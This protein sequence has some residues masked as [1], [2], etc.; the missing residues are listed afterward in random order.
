MQQPSAAFDIQTLSGA[1]VTLSQACNGVCSSRCQGLLGNKPP[2][3]STLLSAVL[4]SGQADSKQSRPC[5]ESIPMLVI[6]VIAK[7]LQHFLQDS[8]P[9]H[10]TM[11]RFAMQ[12][13]HATPD[14]LTT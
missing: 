11:R 8:I 3:S 10:A 4:A 14:A 5:K 1:V 9:E 13:C 6:L 7:H 12:R 2:F